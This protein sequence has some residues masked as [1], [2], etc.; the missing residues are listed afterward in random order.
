MQVLTKHTMLWQE[1]IHSYILDTLLE[2]YS[3]LSLLFVILLNTV[4]GKIAHKCFV[5]LVNIEL[6]IHFNINYTLK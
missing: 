5:L 2:D 4:V 1:Y 6:Y 3:V